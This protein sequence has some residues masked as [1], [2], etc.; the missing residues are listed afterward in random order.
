V[1]GPLG[2]LTLPLHANLSRSARIVSTIMVAE[3]AAPPT[4]VAMASHVWCLPVPVHQGNQARS[5]CTYSVLLHLQ[6]R[7]VNRLLQLQREE[8][9][10][11]LGLTVH[12]GT[13][14]LGLDSEATE[15]HH[16]SRHRQGMSQRDSSKRGKHRACTTKTT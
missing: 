14:G 15:G 9:T 1:Q 12:S 4:H 10:G 7:H 5:R 8:H 13:T 16:S 11:S 2:C 3:M 6:L